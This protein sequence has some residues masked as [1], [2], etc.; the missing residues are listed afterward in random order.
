MGLPRLPFFMRNVR[1]L[2]ARRLPVLPKLRVALY[3][4]GRYRRIL[5]SRQL[6]WAGGECAPAWL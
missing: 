4:R 5:L 3:S 2:G 6:P 1:L